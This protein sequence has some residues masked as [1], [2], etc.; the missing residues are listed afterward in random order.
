MLLASCPKKKICEF[1]YWLVNFD[2]QVSNFFFLLNKNINERKLLVDTDTRD[3]MSSG[4][5]H[6]EGFTSLTPFVGKLKIENFSFLRRL[7]NSD[8][9]C[10][11]MVLIM[12]INYM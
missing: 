5:Q 8:S 11:Y 7:V 10:V 2:A 3:T 6:S 1:L 12:A 9:H 4:L